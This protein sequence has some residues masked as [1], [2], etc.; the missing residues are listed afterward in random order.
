MPSARPRTA[1]KIRVSAAL[2]YLLVAAALLLLLLL[3]SF[4][5]SRSLQ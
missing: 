1:F 5:R 3:H 4:H 2:R